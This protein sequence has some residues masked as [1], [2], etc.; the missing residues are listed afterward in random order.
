MAC[1]SGGVN[2]ASNDLEKMDRMKKA[3]K[4]LLKERMTYSPVWDEKMDEAWIMTRIDDVEKLQEA[5]PELK[6]THKEISTVI[7]MAMTDAE[8]KIEW[9]KSMNLAAKKRAA[10]DEADKIR[11]LCRH[12]RKA[13]YK[14]AKWKGMDRIVRPDTPRR[15]QTGDGQR[16]VTATVKIQQKSSWNK[17]ICKSKLKKNES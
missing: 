3:M 14:K 12:I 2:E 6:A 4:I 15:E 16:G 17:R 9:S 8:D 1:G 11:N 13:W 10:E 5:D 7:I